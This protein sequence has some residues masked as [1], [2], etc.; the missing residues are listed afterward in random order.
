MKTNI[1]KA[2]ETHF[3]ADWKKSFPN[4]F[5]YRLHDQVTGY[6]VTSQ[7]PCD[8]IAYNNNQLWLLETKSH[9]GLSIPFTAIPQYERLLAYK[10]MPGVNPLIIIWFKEKD[11]VLAVPI[12]EAEKMVKDGKKSISLKMLDDQ[13]YNIIEIPSVKKRVFLDS[14]YSILAD[15][16]EGE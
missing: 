9:N 10:N 4:T 2:F 12:I 5:I 11:R 13:S 3:Y 1:G 15:L 14:D 7:N 8:F 6:K 16:K